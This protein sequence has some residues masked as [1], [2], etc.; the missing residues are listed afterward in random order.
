MSYDNQSENNSKVQ[1]ETSIAFD[2][3]KQLAFLGWLFRDPGL[4]AQAARIVKPDWFTDIFARKA[5]KAMLEI[6]KAFHRHPE[7]AEI[8]QWRGLNGEDSRTR[9]KI[10]QIVSRGIESSMGYGLDLIRSDMQSWL[11]A[12]LFVETIQKSVPVF[13]SKDVSRAVELME[14]GF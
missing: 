4:F 14:K 7:P 9:G 8:H 2:E 6:G 11:M 12:T 1:I 13:N 10:E 3:G 5:Y